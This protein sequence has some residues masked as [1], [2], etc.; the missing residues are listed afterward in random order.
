MHS[1]VP[2][3]MSPMTSRR[4]FAAN[5]CLAGLFALLSVLVLLAGVSADVPLFISTWSS[6]GLGGYTALTMSAG[7]IR[8]GWL[9]VAFLALAA[10]D[11]GACC[12]FR[13][14]YESQVARGCNS[15]RWTEYFASASIMNVQIAALS[16]ILDVQLLVCVG[17]LTALCQLA[18]SLEERTGGCVAVRLL[19][20]G[21]FLVAWTIIFANFHIDVQHA[22]NA[23]PTWVY[24]I[25]IV[26]FM[27]E[28]LFPLNQLRPARHANR[29]AGY[30]LLSV[31]AKVSLAAMVWGGLRSIS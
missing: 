23:I 17:V 1:A 25:V 13:H 10:V 31:V 24:A 12:V 20:F 5:A 29:E 4:L 27:L 7:Y 2:E 22:A 26:L 6:D 14:T 3:T 15:F 16:G 18:G 28:C 19:G 9:S 30:L 8:L 21:S 11:H